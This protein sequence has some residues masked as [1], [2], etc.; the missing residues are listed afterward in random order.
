[1]PDYLISWQVRKHSTSKYRDDLLDKAQ[2][3][4]DKA[5]ILKPDEPEN[6]YIAGISLPG[7]FTG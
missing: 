7:P 2:P 6:S 1:M 3:L 5:F 4:I